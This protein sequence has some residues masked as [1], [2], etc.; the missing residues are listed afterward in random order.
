VLGVCVGMQ[1]FARS[2]DE[3]ALQGLGWIPGRVRAL[4]GS[5]TKDAKGSIAE[6]ERQL[7]RIYR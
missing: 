7:K 5:G 4:A 6:A 3:G 2:S 1:M